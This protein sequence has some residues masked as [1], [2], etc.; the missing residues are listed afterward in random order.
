[1]MNYDKDGEYGNVVARYSHMLSQKLG[2]NVE[3]PEHDDDEENSESDDEETPS[4]HPIFL[5][6]SVSLST[7]F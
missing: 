6:L 4:I 5:S 2:S 3:F 1:M 7:T